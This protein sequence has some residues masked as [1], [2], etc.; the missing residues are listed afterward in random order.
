MVAF[1]TI[2]NCL[3]LLLAR[4][5]SISNKSDMV[6]NA[7]FAP[8]TVRAFKHW[9]AIYSK[10]RKNVVLGQSKI[11]L[12]SQTRQV[13]LSDNVMVPIEHFYYSHKH[14]FTSNVFDKDRISQLRLKI[15]QIVIYYK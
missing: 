14:V 1:E 2:R 7:R 10:M 9:A 11:L 12:R 3:Q 15:A 6:R 8:T 13:R 5:I 4:C